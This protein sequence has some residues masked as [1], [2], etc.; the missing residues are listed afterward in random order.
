MAGIVGEPLNSW[1][2]DQ[3]KER[4]RIHGK[5][6]RD[7]ADISYLNNRDAWIK[8]ASGVFLE[9]ESSNPDSLSQFGGGVKYPMDYVLFNG[10][11]KY[12]NESRVTGQQSSTTDVFSTGSMVAGVGFGK[13]YDTS[14]KDYGIV[15]MP[16]IVSLSVKNKNRG[17]IR[18]AN[19]KIKANSKR[20]FDI[21]DEIYLR[22][23]YDMIIEWGWNQYVHNGKLE[24]MGTTIIEEQW[25]GK[26]K[27]DYLYWL[28]ELEKLRHRYKANYDGFYGKVSNFKWNFERDG[29]YSIDIKLISHG[30]V[31]ESLRTSPPSSVFGSLARMPITDYAM[32]VFKDPIISQY[33]DGEAPAQSAGLKEVIQDDG[34][35]AKDENGKDKLSYYELK[36]NDVKDRISEY[37]FNL[38]IIGYGLNSETV[39]TKSDYSA[40]KVFFAAVGLAIIGGAATLLTGGTIWGV[41]AVGGA[42]GAAGGWLT[43]ITDWASEPEHIRY[44]IFDNNWDDKLKDVPAGE[45]GENPTETWSNVLKNA[46]NGYTTQPVTFCHSVCPHDLC[47]RYVGKT[48]IGGKNL[49]FISDE[50]TPYEDKINHEAFF[51]FYAPRDPDPEDSETPPFDPR[52]MTSYIRFGHLLEV[53]NNTSI[54]FNKDTGNAIANILTDVI[55]MYVPPKDKHLSLSYRPSRFIISNRNHNFNMLGEDKDGNVKETI[56]T[57]NVRTSGKW[58][59]GGIN[60]AI[61]EGAGIPYIDARNIYIRNTYIFDKIPITSNDNNETRIDLHGFLKT[62]CT[63]INEALGSINNLEPVVDE[64]TNNV[65]IMDNTNFPGKKKLLR[66]LNLP[67]PEDD[68]EARFQIF[69]YRGSGTKT[70]AGFVRDAGISTKI[71]K[72]IASMITIGA[73]AKG[74]SPNIDATA[75]SKFNA[76][77]INRFASTFAKKSGKAS[78][79]EDKI[80]EAKIDQLRTELNRLIHLGASIEDINKKREELEKA[81]KEMGKT[82]NE[83]LNFQ[84]KFLN[85]IALKPAAYYGYGEMSDPFFN[86]L[87]PF[88]NKLDPT[89]RPEATWNPF[90]SGEVNNPFLPLM[91]IDPE[92]ESKNVRTMANIYARTEAI[93]FKQSKSGSPSVGFIPF[94]LSLTLDGISGI[95]IYSG[96]TTNA[97]FLPSNYPETLEFVTKGVDHDISGNDWTTKVTTIA[98]PKTVDELPEITNK[99]KI[100]DYGEFQEG[101]SNPQAPGGGGTGDTSDITIEANTA[102]KELEIEDNAETYDRLRKSL[103]AADFINGAKAGNV[104]GIWDDG[105][106]NIIAIRNS[107]TA[108]TFTNKFVDLIVIAYKVGD[109][110]RV[111]ATSVS[112][113]PGDKGYGRYYFPQQ[114]TNG[115]VY[116]DSYVSNVYKKGS[117]GKFIKVN[118]KRV[119]DYK[120]YKGPCL[121]IGGSPYY[122][123]TEGSGTVKTQRS[124]VKTVKKGDPWNYKEKY[125]TPKGGPIDE[126][127]YGAK[128]A[129]RGMLIHK[130][131]YNGSSSKV[132]TWSQGCIVFQNFNGIK[133][134][135]TVLHG[136]KEGQNQIGNILDDGTR[137]KFKMNKMDMSTKNDPNGAT[138]KSSFW[139]KTSNKKRDYNL[140]M[141]LSGQ[142]EKSSGFSGSGGGGSW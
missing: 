119:L 134:F 101:G 49:K 56:V 79:K 70:Y 132:G 59:Y 50:K 75:F 91:R 130:G 35:V 139:A 25:F 2:R 76:G 53:I 9:N 52:E 67:I 97:E 74:S 45:D 22:L 77:K 64:L 48:I 90:D 29:T 37:V 100:T 122:Q 23:G 3:V 115:I 123:N 42:T 40:L 43:S 20:Q 86:K 128:W 113:N 65:R 135:F 141:M 38:S 116:S 102:I 71:T 34:N 121:R 111:Y 124:G 117:D 46:S 54:D 108:E 83:V 12:T 126:S 85:G 140:H 41:V 99:T 18:E 73:T 137:A 32:T 133:S 8:M 87:K 80:K 106:P 33:T 72:E 55:P 104:K 7:A 78:N 142:I 69:G 60:Q 31:I 1:V 95:K 96:I 109:K 120:L 131:S 15:P 84:E 39:Y 13:A 6:N 92:L 51:F 98:C 94:E 61:K 16:G 114:F 58:V 136:Q 4:Q 27:V 57:G 5:F 127:N 82:L 62:I 88:L 63:D 68:D 17:S 138:F 26:E 81:A 66:Y 112:T 103:I 28:V 105:G 107:A 89:K 110:K 14:D 125:R 118:G 24:K 11:T 44:R 10:Q 47:G 129:N 93:R 36:L 21:I 19:I 30:D